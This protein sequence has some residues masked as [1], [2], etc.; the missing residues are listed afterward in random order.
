MSVATMNNWLMRIMNVIPKF[1]VS[2]VHTLCKCI[3]WLVH[4]SHRVLFKIIRY[5]FHIPHIL[6][7]RTILSA[8][9]YHHTPCPS[10]YA[11]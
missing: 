11:W 2:T 6:K 5:S 4:T 3:Y 8:Q 7:Y 10:Y 9:I 1:S